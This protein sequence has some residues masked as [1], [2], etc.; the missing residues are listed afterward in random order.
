MMSIDSTLSIL[1]EH[2]LLVVVL[3]PEPGFAFKHALTWEAAYQSL[4]MSKRQEI[5]R[6]VAECYEALFEGRLEEFA[7]HL[8]WHYSAAGDAAM[9]VN[10]ATMAGEAAL[11][12]SAHQEALASYEQALE[13]TRSGAADDQQLTRIFIGRG[14]ALE[15]AAQHEAAMRNYEEMARLGNERQDPAL[16]LSA[17]LAQ[18]TLYSVPSTVYR[19]EEG[20]ALAQE[21]SYL[22]RE[23][24]DH[25]A[26]SHALWILS[27]LEGF[28]GSGERSIEY[29]ET[30]LALARQY[31]YRDQAA[32][33]LNNLSTSYMSAGDLENAGR[34]LEEAA[35]LWR[36]LGNL[37]ML[38]DTL[39]NFSIYYFALGD[40]ERSLKSAEEAQQISLS[41]GNL[42]GQAYGRFILSHAL[43]ELGEWGQALRKAEE[44]LELANQAGFVPPQCIVRAQMASIY[45]DQGAIEHALGLANAAR[46]VAQR[47]Y[48]KWQA[49]AA[50]V[51]ARVQLAAGEVDRAAVTINEAVASLKPGDP[52]AAVTEVSIRLIEA[53]ISIACRDYARVGSACDSLKRFRDGGA[54][55]YLAD[56]M[57]MRGLAASAMK[58][59]DTARRYLEAAQAEAQSNMSRRILWRI[60]LALADLEVD[61]GRPLEAEAIRQQ[62]AEHVGFIADHI[63]DDERRRSFLSQDLVRQALNPQSSR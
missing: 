30:S 31:D 15:L 8:A 59:L 7:A 26:E 27:L 29:G 37:P 39:T 61:A 5:H 1:Q 55:S 19:P 14:R 35:A 12:R 36:E 43:G 54:R 16:K 52:L 46:E 49:Y 50:A 32:F 44:C 20:L 4:L 45:A 58:D 47:L 38:T 56:E 48:P 62:A 9:T 13:S 40:T 11:R 60:M 41:I 51:V 25:R 42:W 21:A 24:G 2:Q 18:A 33:T 57:L 28:S 23:L 63:Q 53:L 10:Y 3:E 22:A 34:S 6:Q 17:L